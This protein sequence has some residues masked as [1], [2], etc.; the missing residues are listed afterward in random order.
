MALKHYAGG[1]LREAS[2]VWKCPTCGAEN[3]GKLEAGCSA[4]GAGGDAKKAAEA[5]A[6][7][8]AGPSPSSAR[9]A[10]EAFLREPAG[11][12]DLWDAFEAGVRWAMDL[13]GK[14]TA[15]D[16]PA[17]PEAPAVPPG[18]FRMALV[19][20]TLPQPLPILVEAR[21]QTTVVA[22]LAFYRD[23][24]LAYGAL[25][26]PLSAAEVDTLIAQLTPPEEE[27]SK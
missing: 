24:Q 19:D 16:R 8:R 25:P 22:A 3:T 2:T 18:G 23:N 17:P 5:E 15:Q 11:P 6:A 26:G 7:F 21:T 1:G 14:V 27:P 20:Y 10:F 12:H 4:C 9:L 13:Q